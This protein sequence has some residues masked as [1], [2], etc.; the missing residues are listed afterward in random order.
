MEK[1]MQGYCL[2]QR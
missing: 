2:R 1:E